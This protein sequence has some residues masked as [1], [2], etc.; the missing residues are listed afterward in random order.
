MFKSAFAVLAVAAMLT[1]CASQASDTN[2]NEPASTASQNDA[3]IGALTSPIGFADRHMVGTWMPIDKAHF[4]GSPEAI[5]FTKDHDKL[6]YRFG[7]TACTANC[8]TDGNFYVTQNPIVWFFAGTYVDLNPNSGH[9]MSL[10]V[11][12]GWDGVIRLIDLNSWNWEL[13]RYTNTWSR[14]PALTVEQL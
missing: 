10:F 12:R 1:G 4:Q 5:V 7:N 8:S 14:N 3:L 6:G 13:G 2:E 9:P 11:S